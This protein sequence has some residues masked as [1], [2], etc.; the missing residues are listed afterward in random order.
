[1]WHKTID[2]DMFKNTFK[3]INVWLISYV[4][5]NNV[6][7]FLSNE[8]ALSITMKSRRMCL[9]SLPQ[10]PRKKLRDLFFLLKFGL[11][12]CFV[13]P[14]RVSNDLYALLKAFPSYLC[15]HLFFTYPTDPIVLILF[16]VHL[17]S[18]NSPLS[19]QISPVRVWERQWLV[20]HTLLWHFEDLN[21]TLL[22]FSLSLFSI[23]NQY[24]TRVFIL[25]WRRKKK[26][27]ALASLRHSLLAKVISR[28]AKRSLFSSFFDIWSTRHRFFPPSTLQSTVWSDHQRFDRIF[29]PSKYLTTGHYF[30]LFPVFVDFWLLHRD[31]SHGRMPEDAT[32]NRYSPHIRYFHQCVIPTEMSDS[33]WN[34]WMEQ[35]HDWTY[36]RPYNSTKK[37]SRSRIRH[38]VGPSQ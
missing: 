20:L 30:S 23:E 33:R 37:S 15:W 34:Y 28:Q 19:S 14:V 18:R 31:Q 16:G 24:A 29:L 32:R 2:S 11:L 1:M 21:G 6:V 4:L 36:S 22:F 13:P 25:G 3:M 7:L 26:N 35:N 9:V 27:A 38:T 17:P 5:H 12:M 8:L 10:I